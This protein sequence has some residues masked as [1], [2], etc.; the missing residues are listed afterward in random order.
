ML[1][2]PP[3]S[4]CRHRPFAAIAAVALALLAPAWVPTALADRTIAPAGPG[5]GPAGC[6][7]IA[8]V[9]ITWNIDYKVDVE[10]LF[11]QRC[12][13]C[14]VDHAGMYEGDLDL[15][16]GV[17]WDNLVGWPSMGDPEVL[18]VAPGEPL[19][20]SLFLKVNCE[21]PGFGERM[22]Y[23][24]PPIPLAE[25]ALIFDWIAAGAPRTATDF[26]FFDGFE[27]RP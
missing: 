16:P 27:P 20:S 7:S 18:R 22:P 23:G 9:P 1:P 6:D 4:R 2:S 10:P 19:A 26:V 13:N 5:P 11:A 3:A 17:S 12:S 8:S 25:Q 21:Q 15:D 24:R 14:H